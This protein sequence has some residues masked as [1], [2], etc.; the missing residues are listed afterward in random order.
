[1]ATVLSPS[2]LVK[3]QLYDGLGRAACTSVTVA[4]EGLFGF[5]NNF[6]TPRDPMQAMGS[7]ID[8]GPLG[9]GSLLCTLAWP[10]IASITTTDRQYAYSGNYYEAD[11]LART[12]KT[13]G[14]GDD[15]NYASDQAV[16][17]CNGEFPSGISLPSSL[18]FSN[19]TLT[20]QFRVTTQQ[21][22]LG[23]LG[24]TTQSTVQD[25]LGR[26]VAQMVTDAQSND[27]VLGKIYHLGADLNEQDAPLMATGQTCLPNYYDAT[28][29]N[30]TQL[31]NVQYN[32]LRQ[33]IYQN[34]P[35][36]GD[37]CKFY[38]TYGRLRFSQT[39]DNA[40]QPNTNSNANN[41]VMYY[42]YDALN[43]V[44]ETGF[45]IQAWDLKLF[46]S[47]TALADASQLP[48]SAALTTYPLRK[49]TYD[50]LGSKFILENMGRITQV[51]SWNSAFD[52]SNN[53]KV[54]PQSCLLQTYVYDSLGRPNQ[55]TLSQSGTANSYYTQYNYDC[56]SNIIG[57]VYPQL[58]AGANFSVN[59]SYNI[60]GQIESI[61][62]PANSVA[63]AA[64]QY[65]AQG[66]IVYENLGSLDSQCVSYS[67]G[68][69]LGQ[70]TE[71]S[72]SCGLMTQKISYT[73]AAGNYQDGN[74]QQLSTYLL[75][76]TGTKDGCYNYTY[77]GFGR[78]TSANA[79]A[80]AWDLSGAVF[81]ANGNVQSVTIAAQK[82]TY[83]YQAK[84]SNQ[85]SAALNSNFAYSASGLTTA[86]T[87]NGNKTV[88]N[89]DQLSA[90]PTQIT[91]PNG[92]V[93]LIYDAKNERYQ[94]SVGNITITYLRGLN[95]RPLSEFTTDN[96]SQTTTTVNYIYG[97]KGLIIINDSG[98]NYVVLKD[99]L[100][101]TRVV[102]Q[103]AETIDSSAIVA[104]FNYLPYGELMSD[105]SQVA[106]SCSIPLRYLYTGQEWDSELGLYN[107]HARQYHPALGR[108]LTPDPAHQFANPY[109]Y[110][111]NNPIN[112][113]DPTG[114]MLKCLGFGA[115]RSTPPPADIQIGNTILRGDA[116]MAP[117]VSRVGSVVPQVRTTDNL[118][119]IIN[120]NNMQV[121][122]RQ[123]EL[124]SLR[125]TP[126]VHE[127]GYLGVQRL[128]GEAG[129]TIYLPDLENVLTYVRLPAV[130]DPSG[131]LT[132]PFTGCT[133]A[134]VRTAD[135]NN[136]LMHAH[137]KSEATGNPSDATQLAA[138]QALASQLNGD[139]VVPP[140]MNLLLPTQLGSDNNA[141]GYLTNNDPRENLNSAFMYGNYQP[142]G[143]YSF[144]TQISNL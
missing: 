57:V 32:A 62:T 134:L 33:V 3:E 109:C 144:S 47:L 61:G 37:I 123:Y 139:A 41:V 116:K 86:I 70:L 89:Y 103:D 78:L 129:D 2:I 43:R 80:T 14:P 119:I 142:D 113:V 53:V 16:S 8:G 17:F 69:T 84:G 56:L 85:L 21:T 126:Y 138:I 36:S 39:A 74:I 22:S 34:F 11:P 107:Y 79:Q 124:D 99:Q 128:P 141:D 106:T 87:T 131:Y 9:S 26:K 76:S 101:S 7:W 15:F 114:D 54:S 118:N 73:D 29:T 58:S 100:G 95:A 75:T 127:N 137:F 46:Q 92:A 38:D 88:F 35:D 136:Y 96:S 133:G 108:F 67:Y 94:K 140:T 59:Y 102:Y 110:V 135:G 49:V 40:L 82:Q 98:S 48:T 18:G 13:S 105:S 20:Q 44:T 115:R 72:D 42:F 66:Q 112:A 111:G 28:Y 90:L 93:N 24:I 19:S 83:A 71:I 77:D 23:S 130:G 27:L 81:D 91:T 55:I 52:G 121:Q 64:Y 120:N 4:N 45:I 51:E 143:T 31:I 65:N 60:Q 122:A 97:P 5:I 6:I 125:V 50:Q 132:G 25:L 68:N 117:V 12:A 10:G 104:Y 63:Y 30:D 1:M